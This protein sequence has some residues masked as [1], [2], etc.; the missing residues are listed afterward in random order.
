MGTQ[1]NQLIMN[2]T[3]SNN[4]LTK[5]RNPFGGSHTNLSK[6][7]NMCV[8]KEEIYDRTLNKLFSAEIAPEIPTSFAHQN[9]AI[10]QTFATTSNEAPC[11]VCVAHQPT[12]P[13][14]SCARDVCQSCVYECAQC[15]RLA[16]TLCSQTSYAN[17]FEETFCIDCFHFAQRH[18]QQ[19]Q[20]SQQQHQQQDAPVN[21]FSQLTMS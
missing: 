14:S 4:I 21:R 18:Q 12:V 10:A 9:T 7:M 1:L 20:C 8:D 6:S 15:S 11:Y 13:C 2:T 19:E 3:N 16:C 17:R 5:R